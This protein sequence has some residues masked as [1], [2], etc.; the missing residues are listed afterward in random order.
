MAKKSNCTANGKPAYRVRL[1][2]GTSLEGK[3]I[4]KSFYGDG[5]V[6]AERKRDEYVAKSQHSKDVDITF[7]ALANRFTYQILPNARLAPGTVTLYETQYR[8]NLK[9]SSLCIKPV[10]E[11]TSDDIHRYMQGDFSDRQANHKFMKRLFKWLNSE[12]YCPDYMSNITLSTRTKADDISVFT[13]EEVQR[14]LDTPNDLHFLFVLAFASGLRL[15]ELLA[16]TFSDFRDGSIH[17]TKQ[18]NEYYDVSSGT[19]KYK[20]VI[21]EPK[22]RN[23][24][25][26]IPLPESVWSEYKEYEKEKKGQKYLFATSGGTLIGQANFHRAWMRHLKRSGV[27]YRKFHSCRA[28]YCTLLCRSGVPLETAS[29][30]MGHSDVSTTAKFYRMVADEELTKAVQKID[31]IFR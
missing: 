13:E 23:S 5:K 26:V 18:V 15:G 14:I 31:C 1:R 17:V 22:S 12:G 4:Y 30:L 28:T 16:L 29:K 19:R 11:I 6:E 2:V 20:Q 10:S 21:R 9:N 7:G 25:R 27:E 24:V 8:K 3:P